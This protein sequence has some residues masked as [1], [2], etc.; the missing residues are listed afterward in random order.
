MNNDEQIINAIDHYL[1]RQFIG[2]PNDLPK[3]ECRSEAEKILWF[4]REAEHDVVPIGEL[5]D[6]YFSN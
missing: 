5:I 1:T 3:G 6:A 4:I 2:D